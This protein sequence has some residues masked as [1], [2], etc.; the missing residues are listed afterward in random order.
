MDP[1]VILSV[2]GASS[3]GAVA[4]A[5]KALIS[6]RLRPKKVEQVSL[7][8]QSEIKFVTVTDA[9]GNTFSVTPTESEGKLVEGLFEKHA[10]DRDVQNR[11]DDS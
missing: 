2:V 8:P 3:L 5:A 4:T 1:V 6:E 7:T 11:N 9:D 10:A